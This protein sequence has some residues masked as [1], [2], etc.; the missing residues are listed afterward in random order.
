MTWNSLAQV[1]TI[2][3]GGRLRL[4]GK[5]FVSAGIPAYGAGGLNGHVETPEYEGRDAIILS[6]IGARCGKCFLATGSWTTLANTQVILPHENVDTR[7]LWRQLNDERSWHRSGTAQPFIKPSDVKTRQVWLPSLDEQRRIASIFDEADAIRAKR[8]AQLAHLDELPQA[9][10]QEMFGT[11]EM[12]STLATHL[13]FLT[14]G[15]RGW[16]K[17]YAKNGAKFLRIQNVRDGRLHLEDLAFVDVPNSMEARR[18]RTESGD[19]LVSITADLGRVAAI[20]PNFGEAHINQHLALLRAPDFAPDFL[21]A[22]LSSSRGQ[23]EI[24]GRD[25]GATKAGLNF[26]NI[27]SVRIPTPP[28]A[29]QQEF[30]ERV[31][32]INV[33]RKRITQSLQAHDEMLA[34]LQHNA[35]HGRL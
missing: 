6:S 3:G 1:A 18:T 28:L 33:E 22:Y 32:S 8:R 26:D 2:H 20:P 29:D 21:A 12:N 10:F 9:L 23:R 7:F 34:T 15:S 4:S 25:R 16:A 19:V 17:H 14:S 31:A 27:R 5:D 11:C 24:L 13:T 35:F 30:A